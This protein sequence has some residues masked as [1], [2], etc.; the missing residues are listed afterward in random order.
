[1]EKRESTLS[2]MK[3]SFWSS[4]NGKVTEQEID[5]GAFEGPV[6]RV[7]ISHGGTINM[8]NYESSRVEVGIE[9]PCYVEE[10]PEVYAHLKATIE[11]KVESEIAELRK[12]KRF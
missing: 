3:G 9:C 7:S 8:G 6:A 2:R 4:V 12:V 5:V 1:M 10:I 11:A